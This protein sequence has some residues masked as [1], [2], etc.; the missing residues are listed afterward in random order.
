M[1]DRDPSRT[2]RARGGGGDTQGGG[3]GVQA[4]GGGTQAAEGGRTAGVVVLVGTPIGN[5]GDLSARAAAALAG[6]TVVYC[7]DT[8]RTRALMAHAGIT[9]VPLR[10][11]HAHN[12]RARAAEAV[13][14]ALAGS[15]VAVATDAGMPGVSDPG[16]QVVAAAVEAGV[17]VTVV[18]GPSAPVTALVVSG[19]PSDRFCFEGFL[20]RSGADRRARLEAIAGADRTTVCFE[21]PGRAAATL[22]DLLDA[23][24]PDR[25]VAVARELTKLH[26]EV[27][28]GVLAGAVAWAEAG[29]VRGEVVLVVGAAPRRAVEVDDDAIRA[30][31][32]DRRAS[33]ER[34]RGAVDAVAAELGVSRR[35]VY[36]IAVGQAPAT[37][38]AGNDLGARGVLRGGGR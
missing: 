1:N 35:R 2:A 29:E 31:V 14:A 12:E 36:A 11:M 34:T 13:A 17:A 3:G 4:A 10:S 8:R 19:L 30:A 9:G 32:A 27:W 5:L 21:A 38:P 37:G 22:R 26:E 24:G 23:C 25:P 16:E 18:P 6:A 28:R 15:T 20:P 7:E 33:G